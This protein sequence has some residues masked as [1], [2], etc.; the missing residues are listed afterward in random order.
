MILN[1]FYIPTNT[2]LKM[3]SVTN[4]KGEIHLDLET[5]V[6]PI[7]KFSVPSPLM[8]EQDS[9]IG[10]LWLKFGEDYPFVLPEEADEQEVNLLFEAGCSIALIENGETVR[11]SVLDTFF[12]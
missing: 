11:L 3:V 1:K 10:E 4:I 12:G 5:V 2:I 6:N 7:L 8:S 9:P